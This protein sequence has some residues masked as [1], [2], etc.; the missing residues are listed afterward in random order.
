MATKARKLDATL[1]GSSENGTKLY[2]GDMEL[3]GTWEVARYLGIEKSRIARWLKELAAGET[4]IE[5]PVAR[6]KVWPAV[7]AGAGGGEAEGDVLGSGQ[8]LR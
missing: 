1:Y 6:L 4:P 5:A 7:D 3:L 2:A 8:P